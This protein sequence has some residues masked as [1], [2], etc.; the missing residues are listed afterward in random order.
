MVLKSGLSDIQ[1]KRRCAEGVYV[2]RLE[3]TMGDK[4][5]CGVTT[6]VPR[7]LGPEGDKSFVSSL[8]C[9][10]LA[11]RMPRSCSKIQHPDSLDLTL[12]ST[13]YLEGGKARQNTRK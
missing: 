1:T 13:L 8:Q 12:I 7:G 5:P 4:H 2:G 10:L 3:L 9:C 11:M 6:A